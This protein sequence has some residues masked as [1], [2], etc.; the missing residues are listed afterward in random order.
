MTD[1]EE[2]KRRD[3]AI[4]AK[5]HER[6]QEYMQMYAMGKNLSTRV[7]IHTSK[8]KDKEFVDK[9]K[10]AQ[11]RSDFFNCTYNDDTDT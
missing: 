11:E 5:A 1:H 4:G 7:V 3:N 6:T 2:Q 10:Y 8:M 9:M